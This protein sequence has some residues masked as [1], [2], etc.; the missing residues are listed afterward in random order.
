MTFQER[1]RIGSTGE[2]IIKSYLIN[3]GWVVYAP[4]NLSP[5]PFDFLCYKNGSSFIAEV[6][7]KP[8]MKFYNATGIDYRHYIIYRDYQEK[9]SL[10]VFIFFVDYS[11]NLIYG[12]YLNELD[13]PYTQIES[14]NRI[15]Y[16]IINRKHNIITFPLS[17]M[18][19]IG[20]IN[21]K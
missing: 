12:N 13:K 20:F 3:N 18:K 6:K 16:P 8:K 19:F 17:L 1:L 21:S 4:E 7:T 5:H 11:L 10:P 9:H 2:E 15:V 14:G